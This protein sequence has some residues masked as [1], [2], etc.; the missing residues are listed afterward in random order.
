MGGR[1]RRCRR[2]ADGGVLELGV[3]LGPPRLRAIERAR[4]D[5]GLT[6]HHI[7]CVW[8]GVPTSAQA[9][10]KNICRFFG[11][12]ASA[13]SSPCHLIYTI[14]LFSPLVLLFRD[15]A[16]GRASLLYYY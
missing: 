14:P 2:T 13:E 9:S 7:H 15:K 10:D 4:G 3:P 6:L 12:R 5:Y 16:P 8:T 1:G 11:D